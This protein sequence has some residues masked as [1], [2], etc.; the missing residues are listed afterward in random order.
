MHYHTQH[1]RMHTS[2]Y[3]EVGLSLTYTF[4]A[5]KERRHEA[6]DTS[7]FKQE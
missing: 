5:Y 3:R 2:S 4:G 6:V 7:R 1:F